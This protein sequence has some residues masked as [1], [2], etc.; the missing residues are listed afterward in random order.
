MT[1]V[2]ASTDVEI[3]R[4]CTSVGLLYEFFEVKVIVQVKILFYGVELAEMC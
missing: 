4:G 1:A 3:A 2:T